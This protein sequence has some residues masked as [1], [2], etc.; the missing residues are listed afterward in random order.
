MRKVFLLFKEKTVQE[1][2]E[3]LPPVLF[4]PTNPDVVQDLLDVL[5]K[6]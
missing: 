3:K 4:R 2:G 1:E 5:T 6:D